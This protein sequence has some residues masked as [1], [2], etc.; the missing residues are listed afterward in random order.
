MFRVKFSPVHIKL[1]TSDVLLS[2]KHLIFI[3]LDGGKLYVQ[4]I[5]VRLP[6]VV[7][8]ISSNCCLKTITKPLVPPWPHF[9]IF[10]LRSTT[11]AIH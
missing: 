7:E 8:G 11:H 1:T 5:L 6:L 3:I 4:I 10:N 2:V 9:E